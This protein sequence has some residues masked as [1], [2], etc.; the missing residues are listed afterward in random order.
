MDELLRC[1][2]C[3]KLD[4]KSNFLRRG[5]CRCGGRKVCGSHPASL[6]EEIKVLWWEVQLC[7]KMKKRNQLQ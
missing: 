6:L 3:N 4:L 1:M 2:A 5:R 7:F